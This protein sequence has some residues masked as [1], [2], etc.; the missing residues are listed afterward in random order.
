MPI[1]VRLLVGL[2]AI[3]GGIAIAAAGIFEFFG[4]DS[5]LVIAL[6]GAAAGA[7]GFYLVVP[8]LQDF[9][10][11]KNEL[12]KWAAES[13]QAA[14]ATGSGCILLGAAIILI[15]LWAFFGSEMR[16]GGGKTLGLGLGL[17]GG[18]AFLGYSI[19][20]LRPKNQNP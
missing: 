17:G 9:P 5:S 2:V 1:H 8:L 4:A 14:L 20:R 13:P 19:I 3:V 10:A 16:R 7:A 18:L 15:C 6:V 11:T 12:S